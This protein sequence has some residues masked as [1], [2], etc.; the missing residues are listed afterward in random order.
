MPTDSCR[1]CGN[2]LKHIFC[3]LGASPLSNSYLK[4]DQLLEMEPTFPLRVHVC[5]NCLLVQLQE[6]QNP[7]AIFK[8]YAYFSSYSESWLEHARNYTEYM[9][10]R[11]GYGSDSQ[12]IEIASNDGYLLQYFKEEGVPVLGIEPAENV[13]A[14]ARAAGIET[15]TNFFGVKT[16]GQL[17]GDGIYADLLLGNNV[18]AHVP[19]INDFV[20]G[21]KKVLKPDGVITMEF[22]HLLRLMEGNQFDT[23]YH[24]HFS[25]FS[26]ITVEKIFSKHG[27]SLFDV[28]ELQTHGGSLR[29]FACHAN[30]KSKTAGERV[31]EL[32]EVERNKGLEDIRTYI[33]FQNKVNEA[34][35][36]IL[37]FLI[38]AKRDGKKIAGYGAPAK[39]NTLLNFCGIRT[40]FIDFTVDRNP[41]KQ[42]H[43]LPGTR[44]P[45]Y[46][47]E[48]IDEARPDYLVILPWNIMHE[49]ME[50]MDRVR[51]WGCKFVI[52]IPKVEVIE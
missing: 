45:V 14:V 4:Q 33:S 28:E 48:K 9:I 1:F 5:D 22:P 49:V 44:I 17:S 12:I 21:M 35:R 20:A 7:E 2:N 3:D 26:L 30:D 13:A 50:Q 27:L 18:L 52:L 51:E 46:P 42:G 34:K 15:M 39:G 38:R 36:N 43:F 25:Y 41:N 37:D 19:D 47:P 10:E 32:R 24:E 8:D 31:G 23:I 40:D 11:F 6:F 29:I 16:A